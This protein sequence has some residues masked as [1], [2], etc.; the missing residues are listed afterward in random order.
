[1]GDAAGA[2][3]GDL[4]QG[5]ANHG[6]LIAGI[7]TGAG[8][9]V[10]VDLVRQGGAVDDTEAEVEEEVGDAS[11]ETDGG[12]LLLFG[13]FEECTE[14][15]TASALAFG[16]GFDD[17]RAHF[18]EMRAIEVEGP[19]TEKDARFG[20]GHSEVADVLADLGVAATQKGSIAGKRV[21]EVEDVDSV[22]ELSFADD[23]SASTE[24]CRHGRLT[25]GGLE[26]GGHEQ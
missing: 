4:G 24:A 12:D 18:G 5:T 7:E 17:D 26:D 22:G 10:L 19:T 21:D 15:T 3:D 14:E 8:L 6:N 20:F 9:A 25:D 1:L 2:E 11:E 16:F 23:S 13:L